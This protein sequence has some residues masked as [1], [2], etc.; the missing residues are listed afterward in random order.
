MF[1]FQTFGGPV[2]LDDEGQALLG[3]AAQRRTLGVLSVLAVAGRSG[4]TRDKLIGILWPESPTRLARHSLTQALYSARKALD[5]DDLFLGSEDLR[6]NPER[7]RTDIEALE[8]A[9]ATCDD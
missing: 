9:L 6:L 3:G 1:W 2:L 5:C 7:I 4:L 8:A